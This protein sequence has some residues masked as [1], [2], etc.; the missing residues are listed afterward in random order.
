M[1][2]AKHDWS[3]H[4]AAI[5]TQGISTRAYARQHDLALSTLYY[6]QRK[7]QPATVGGAK[8]KPVAA[9]TQVGKF[10][11]LRVRDLGDEV[12]RATTGCTLVL[13]GG[14]RLEMTALPEPQ[15]LAALGRCASA[16]H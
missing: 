13:T 14:M 15:W 10:V 16:G 9:N 5:K 3:G 6:W 11:A 4:V 8:A 1:K 2:K 7:L 12:A